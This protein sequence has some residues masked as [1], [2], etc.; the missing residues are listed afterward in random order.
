M[1]ARVPLFS[2][3]PGRGN[4]TQGPLATRRYGILM[5]RDADDF[6]SN[7]AA[8]VPFLAEIHKSKPT[9]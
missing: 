3:A 9:H 4:L 5:R 1:A 8:L 2:A 6:D 7:D